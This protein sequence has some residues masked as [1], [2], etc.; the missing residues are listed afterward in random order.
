MA[1]PRRSGRAIPAGSSKREKSGPLKKPLR[2]R[3][4]L[5]AETPTDVRILDIAADHIRRHGMARTTILSIAAEAGMSHANIYRYYPS[6]M[7]LIAEISAQ[8]LK[9][10]EAALHVI[11]DAP[12]PAFDKLERLVFALHRAYRDKIETDPSIFALFA[13]ASAQGAPIARRHYGRRDSEM[14]RILDEGA[15]GHGFDQVD[16]KRALALILDAAYRFIDPVAMKLDLEVPRT[17]LE[18]R[19]ARVTTTIFR[20]LS[21]GRI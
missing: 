13:A 17:I 15:S 5:P 18:Q 8:W 10:L 1:W 14:R 9:P 6:K 4:P 2:L 7:A 3:D 16:P 11:G 20:A 21:S 19:M 12:D